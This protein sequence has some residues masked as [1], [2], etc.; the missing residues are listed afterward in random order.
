MTKKE[1]STIKTM[2][3]KALD[4]MENAIKPDIQNMPT[5]YTRKSRLFNLHRGYFDGIKEFV[6]TTDREF[7]N[8]IVMKYGDIIGKLVDRYHSTIEQKIFCNVDK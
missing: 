6:E 3:E 1:K 8:E 7:Y 5:T 4:G 2:L